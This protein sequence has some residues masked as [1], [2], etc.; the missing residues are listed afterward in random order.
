MANAMVIANCLAN[1]C[2]V[3]AVNNLMRA[4]MIKASPETLSF[5]LKFRPFFFWSRSVEVFAL[6]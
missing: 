5:T 2:A 3:V 1:L 4:T 6:A